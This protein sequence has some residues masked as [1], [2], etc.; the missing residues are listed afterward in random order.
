MPIYRSYG[1]VTESVSSLHWN[2]ERLTFYFI[3]W[4]RMV[5]LVTNCTC[6]R[7]WQKA[8]KMSA[9]VKWAIILFIR[10]NLRRRLI[11]R[12]TPAIMPLPSNANARIVPSRAIST[13]ANCSSLAG[14][15]TSAGRDVI[16][17]SSLSLVTS[18]IVS[19][20][21]VTRHHQQS[22]WRHQSVHRSWHCCRNWTSSHRIDY[23]YF[24]PSPISSGESRNYEVSK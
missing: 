20:T 18:D 3:V 6:G 24:K 1:T 15:T 11:L 5:S 2:V 16:A 21:S 23:V 17:T 14:R 22:W 19:M 9:T 10:V 7:T 12:S 8:T 13:R 4:R